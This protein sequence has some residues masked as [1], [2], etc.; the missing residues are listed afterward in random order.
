ME[1]EYSY[2]DIASNDEE[3]KTNLIKAVSYPIVGVS[4]LPHFLKCAKMVVPKNIKLSTPIDYPMGLLDLKSRLSAVEYSIKNGANTIELVAPSHALCNRKYDRI[5]DDIRANLDLCM[6]YSVELRYMVDYRVF[7]YDTLYKIA[8]I[9]ISSGIA[10]IYPS[11]SNFLDDINDN[12]IASALINKKV[13]QIKII[14]TGNL[15][16]IDQAKTVKK[17]NLYGIKVNS[18]NAL[19]LL[20]KNL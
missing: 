10:T 2:Y 20:T 17:A 9:F 3:I 1:I 15:W 7:S 16:N 4:V 6:Q 19:D 12:I 5:R 8:Q 18:I 13:S 14:C 11:T